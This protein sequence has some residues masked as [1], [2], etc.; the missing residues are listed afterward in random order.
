MATT[1]YTEGGARPTYKRPKL[2]TKGGGELALTKVVH[3]LYMSDD[4]TQVLT[5]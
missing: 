5:L 2:T 4:Y 1:R 3:Q